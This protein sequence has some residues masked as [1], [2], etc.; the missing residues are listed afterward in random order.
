MHRPKMMA[1]LCKRAGIPPTGKGM[2]KIA[3]GKDKG[4]IREVDLYMGFH[5]LRHFMAT[6]LADRDKV[7]TKAVS[8]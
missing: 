5:A 1:S 7:T 4:K 3:R 2:R 6:Y 8:G